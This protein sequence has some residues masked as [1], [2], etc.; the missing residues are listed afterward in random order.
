MIT[1]AY[2]EKKNID[3]PITALSVA[4]LSAAS[5]VRMKIFTLDTCLV[6][7]KIGVLGV[8]DQKSVIKLF[9]ELFADMR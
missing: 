8:V 6:R 5:M 3:V 9:K 2:H 7:K 1:S 4:G